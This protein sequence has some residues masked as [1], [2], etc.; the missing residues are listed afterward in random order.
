VVAAA[1]VRFCLQ[2]EEM[3]RIIRAAGFEPV[4]RNMMY[5]PVGVSSD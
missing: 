2:R 5:E 1:G 4:Q 3:H